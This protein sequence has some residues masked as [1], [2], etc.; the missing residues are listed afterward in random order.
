[1]ISVFEQESRMRTCGYLLEKQKMPGST[2]K[3]NAT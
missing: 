1:M 3:P 2:R